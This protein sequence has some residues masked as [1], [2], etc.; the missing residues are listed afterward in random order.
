MIAHAQDDEER[1]R[2]QA[3]LDTALKFSDAQGV[4][5]ACLQLMQPCPA[6]DGQATP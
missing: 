4:L 2:V 6:R 3:A 5:M 1:A